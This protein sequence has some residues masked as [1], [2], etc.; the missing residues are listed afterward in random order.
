M[1]LNDDRYL[2]K[3]GW[4]VRE[5]WRE[6]EVIVKYVILK[7]FNFFVGYRRKKNLLDYHCFTLMQP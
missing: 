6:F 2:V 5:I 1:M 4:K 7:D 3:K